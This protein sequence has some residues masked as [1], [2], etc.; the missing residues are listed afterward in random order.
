[1][2]ESGFMRHSDQNLVTWQTGPAVS[3]GGMGMDTRVATKERITCLYGLW[4]QRNVTT[5]E[6][7]AGAD[8]QQAA[9]EVLY[10]C[11]ESMRKVVEFDQEKTRNV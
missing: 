7:C 3:T 8:F 9:Y 4:G 10:E 11:V 1:M 5:G 6:T 2:R